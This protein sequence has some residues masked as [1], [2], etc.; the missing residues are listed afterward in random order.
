MF[1][2]L[3]KAGLDVARMEAYT[4][5]DERPSICACVM[6]HGQRSTSGCMFGATAMESGVEITVGP[7]GEL[8]KL[9]R[10]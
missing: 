4:A 3:E 2:A 1:V 7:N 6:S 5:A 8:V 9:I 10:K